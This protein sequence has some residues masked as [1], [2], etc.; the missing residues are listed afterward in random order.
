MGVQPEAHQPPAFRTL[1]VEHVEIVLQHLQ[2]LGAGKVAPEEEAEI[3][4][5]VRIRDFHQRPVPGVDQIGLVVVHKIVVEDQPQLGQ[6][7]GR[8][9]GAA[10]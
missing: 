3:A 8:L 4:G 1:L 10:Q 9:R 2:H 5:L 7:L 6:D